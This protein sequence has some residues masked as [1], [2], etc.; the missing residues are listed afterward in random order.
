MW[1]H[2]AHALLSLP[3]ARPSHHGQATR[4]LDASAGI[5][6]FGLPKMD[7]SFSLIMGVL[8]MSSRT[9]DLCMESP[10]RHQW[11]R[12]WDRTM[13]RAFNFFFNNIL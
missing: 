4:I 7:S 6:E 5:Q 9:L 11:N 3:S 1:V 10:L 12:I 13:E 2:N 8:P